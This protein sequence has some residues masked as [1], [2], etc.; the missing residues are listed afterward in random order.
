MNRRAFK[1]SRIQ[2]CKKS[3]VQDANTPSVNRSWQPSR[4]L[5]SMEADQSPSTNRKALE[6]TRLRKEFGGVIALAGVDVSIELDRIIG[7]IGPNGSGKTTLFNI[8]AG[9]HKPTAGSVLWQ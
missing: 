2:E 8:V 1:N 3:G 7:I 6:I 5:H 4:N 9:V